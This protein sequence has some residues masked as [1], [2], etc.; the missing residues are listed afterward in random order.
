MPGVLDKL[1]VDLD[2]AKPYI[3]QRDRD[4]YLLYCAGEER[5]R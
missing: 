3:Y 5:H 1:P 2:N 4:G